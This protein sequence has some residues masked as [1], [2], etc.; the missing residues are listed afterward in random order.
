MKLNTFEEEL[1]IN[2][3]HA[4][5]EVEEHGFQDKKTIDKQELIKSVSK[6]LKKDKDL[7]SYYSHANIYFA[8][9]EYLITRNNRKN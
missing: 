8:I 7:W 9:T 3:D 1:A 4:I 2:L 6:Y 5:A